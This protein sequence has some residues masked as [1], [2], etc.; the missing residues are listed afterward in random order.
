MVI[1]ARRA[2]QLL[3]RRGVSEWSAR[4]VL[5]SGLAGEPIRSGS[6]VLYDEARVTEL[7]QRPS[8]QWPE[9]YAR[10]PAGVFVSRR[11]FD[12][13]GSRTEQLATLSE[14][15]SAVCPWAWV[16]MSLR[17]EMV[18]YFPFVATVGGLVVLGADIVETRG[19]SRL[20]LAPPGDWFEAAAGHWMPT[21]RGRRWFLDLGSVSA[22]AGLSPRVTPSGA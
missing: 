13:A 7:A 19:F 6:A 12:A 9:F 17:L 18:G 11:D 10:C 21:G 16:G 1:G 5:E 14:G 22:T 4:K 8:V 2:R 15:W 20:V 3:T